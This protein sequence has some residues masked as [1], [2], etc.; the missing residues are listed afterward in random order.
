[1]DQQSK[2]SECNAGWRLDGMRQDEMQWMDETL[3]R[4]IRR[5]IV[6]VDGVGRSA[7]E[8][9]YEAMHETVVNPFL[10]W[11]DR[12]RGLAADQLSWPERAL[13]AGLR[14]GLRSR[15]RRL[16]VVATVAF[17]WLYLFLRCG[18]CGQ[19]ASSEGALAQSG[20][21]LGLKS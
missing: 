7:V 20:V 1:V 4:T 12:E 17:F 8:A 10:H 3:D 2:P 15:T 13:L 9:E 16:L 19:F 6:V 11:E 5:P 21:T 14:Q 18:R